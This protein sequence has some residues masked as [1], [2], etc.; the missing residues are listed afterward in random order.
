[1]AAHSW[2]LKSLK[3]WAQPR[4]SWLD[5][6]EKIA[7]IRTDLNCSR[8]NA[9][10]R[11]HAD[12]EKWRL[13]PALLRV[14][15]SRD[16]DTKSVLHGLR[17]E[18]EERRRAIVGWRSRKDAIQRRMNLA[19]FEK[20][21]SQLKK[22][23]ETLKRSIRRQKDAIGLLD[24]FQ[25][26]KEHAAAVEA[27]HLL[28]TKRAVVGK[29]V[30]EIALSILP[31]GS[32]ERAEVEVLERRIATHKLEMARMGARRS[33]LQ[34][35]GHGERD[36]FNDWSFRSGERYASS[37]EA[38]AHMQHHGAPTRLLDW[39]ESLA[40]G[41]YFA[42]SKYRGALDIIW[43]DCERK[44]SQKN[45]G[46]KDVELPAVLPL[47]LP[48]PSVW[49]LNPYELAGKAMGKKSVL[50]PSLNIQNDY[51]RS[52]F[53]DEDWPFH[54]PIPILSPWT[55]NRIAAQGGLFTVWGR[56]RRA[57]DKQLSK[58]RN[59]VNSGGTEEGEIGQRQRVLR[60]VRI[61]PLAAIYGVRF[62]R[63]FVGLS[64]FTVFRDLDSLGTRV[65]DKF[66]DPTSQ[67][68]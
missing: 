20:M 6:L 50:N 64:D 62:L 60:E 31:A 42:L 38:L 8:S 66:I 10:F 7:L 26:A 25:Q 3:S 63:E 51:F 30:Q 14:R 24:E 48:E 34:A 15:Q 67:F 58:R 18:M 55:N 68:R 43:R 2:K 57:L 41:I 46:F 17:S 27:L 45:F 11:G 1:M 52:F 35:Q 5:F 61:P 28:E 37:W 53:L 32:M 44:R 54:H 39:T 36:A 59:K 21:P 4:N 22:E 29:I 19:I 23:L 33:V 40:V 49:I 13:K 9:W 47:G 12:A 65:K 56:C 16:P